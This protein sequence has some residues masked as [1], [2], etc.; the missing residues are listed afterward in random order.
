MPAAAAL[1]FVLLAAAARAAQPAPAAAP[2]AGQPPAAD[3][4]PPA[5]SARAPNGLPPVVMAIEVR[6]DVPL[7][8]SNQLAEVIEI[9][10]GKPLDD[11][12]VRHTLRNLVATGAASEV[13]LY[14][15][16]EPAGVVA[17]IVVRPVVEVSEV[18][19]SGALGLPEADLKAA[20]PQRVAQPLAEE[21]VV[22]G[23]YSLQN[24]Y[25]ES[26]YFNASVHVAVDTKPAL[27]QAVVTYQ[28]ASGP[29]ATVAAIDFDGHVAPLTPAALLERFKSRPGKPYARRAAEDEAERLQQWLV[30]KGYAAARVDK[31]RENVDRAANSVRLTYPI[32][33]G[34]LIS[35]D[36]RGADAKKLKR[37]GLLPFLGAAGYDEALVQQALAKIKTYYQQQGHYKVKVEQSEQRSEAALH[38]VISIDPGAVYTLDAVDWRGNREI[39][40]AQLVKLM[41]TAPHSLIRPGSGRL[42]QEVLDADLENIRSYYGLQGYT[43]AKVGPAEVD[44]RGHVLRLTV[45]IVEGRRQRLVKLE[46]LGVEKLDV[47][48]LRQSLPLKESGPFHPTL[49]DQTLGAIRNAYAEKGFMRAQVSAEQDWDRSHTLVDVVIRVLEGPQRVVD[50]VIVRGN[51]RTGEQVIRRALAV[52]HGEPIGQTKLYELESSLYRLGIFSRV[53]VDLT[54]SGLD[55]AERDLLVRVEEGK[56]KSLTYGAGYDTEHGPRALLGFSNNDL[57]GRA[58]SLRSDFRLASGDIRARVL[59]NQPNLGRYDVPL[60]TG[61]FF[62]DTKETSFRVQRWGARSEAVKVV[63][64]R[65]YSL[66]LDYRVVE[67]RVNP[68]VAL[69]SIE[70][71]NRPYRLSSLVPSL[72]LDHRDDPLV[73]SRGW[74]SLVQLQYSFPA[75]GSSAEFLKL[76]Y[77]QTQ[78]V[79]LGAPGVLAGSVRLGGIEAFRSLGRGDPDV[80]ATLPSSN[81]PIDERFFAGGSTTDRAYNLDLLGIRGQSLLQPAG[82]GSFSPVGGN[83]LLLANFDY[84][85]P[86]AGPIGGT[87]FFDLGNIWADWRDIRLNGLKSGLGVGVRYNSPIGPLRAEI[88]WKLRRAHKPDEPGYVV[89]LSFGNPF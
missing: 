50:R 27:R 17:M 9:E 43:E 76:F 83:G 78:Y 10:V 60:S 13:E 39:G 26:G 70:R 87:L 16:A 22:Q 1:P 20:V 21:S 14:T 42:V 68:G 34:P 45:P 52:K 25:E 23:V 63:S 88:G 3:A 74:S 33:V 71:Q 29:R 73:P 40:S 6:S 67:L 44:E 8:A 81:I 89:F 77:Q 58:Y 30:E 62:F 55:T 31:P 57:A 86:I 85:F 47:A 38:I 80:P 46:L 65:R 35:L 48:K 51:R 82:S 5:T 75:L 19:I 53:D 28:V 41:A 15:S 54:G 84:R 18:R 37:K 56:A 7:P 64:H 61:L 24:L 66:A 32:S 36:V 59:L 2:E 12:A 4:G 72:L 49:L 11:T 69:N 79:N